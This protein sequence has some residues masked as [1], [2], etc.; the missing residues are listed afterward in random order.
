MLAWVFFGYLTGDDVEILQS[1]FSRAFGLAYEP[2]NLRHLLL[3]DIVVA[4]VLR[5]ASVLGVEAIS[6]KLWVARLPFVALAT[7]NV[8]LVFQIG[9]RWLGDHRPAMLAATFYGFH[10]IPLSYGS[11]VYARTAT[12]ACVLLAVLLISS[13]AP[14]PFRLVLSGGALAIAFA[15]RFSE[16][17]FLLPC[18]AVL[19]TAGGGI[20][21][22]LGRALVVIG[23]TMGI[24]T[25]VI[26]MEDWLT[27]GRPFS[28]LDC[29][30]R[31]TIIEKNA[32]A[33]LGNQ[34]W[35]WYLRR[36]PKWVPLTMLPFF[37]K[38]VDWSLLKR[39]LLL[40][41]LPLGVLTLIHHKELRYL[42]GIV[43][44][45]CLAG[46]AGAWSWWQLGRRKST[47]L[48]VTL[49]LLVGISGVTQL[50]KGS[51][52]A[53]LA[54]RD[55]A[56]DQNLRRVALSQAWAYGS[57]LN[58][59]GLQIRD[60]PVEPTVADLDRVVDQC[61]VVALYRDVIVEHHEI[62]EWLSDNDYSASE[63]YRHFR[64][65]PV[66]VYRWMGANG[67]EAVASI[68]SSPPM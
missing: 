58:L 10:W 45:V 15:F 35:Y 46:A 12:T 36:L 27:W 55:L 28:S 30:F 42:Q 2:W 67:Y 49:S 20:G 21:S 7:L 38:N 9:R 16:V 43:P 63:T 44:F 61:Q 26:G 56:K 17:I 34:P 19:V 53:V 8:F 68:D 57:N 1:G 54:A 64:S 39:P 29:F 47:I 6:I 41:L 52:A 23:A 60:L 18:V 14:R 22:R 3:P 59:E 50:T 31:Y 32:S 13:E 37:F 51:M 65:R 40:T 5:L 66:I 4:P 48:L 11:T 33:L 62:V 24:A 25:L